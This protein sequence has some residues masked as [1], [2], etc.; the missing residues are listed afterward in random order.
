MAL[1]QANVYSNVLG[2]EVAIELIIPQTTTKVIGTNTQGAKEDIPVLYLLHGMGGN[3][4]V[5]QRRTAIERYV[6]NYNLAVVMPSTD[7]GF[8]TDTTYDMNY[9]TY[10]SEE[11]PQ[12]IHELFPQLSTKREKTFAA[13]LSMGGY[14]AVKLGLR[15]P[16]RFAAVASLSGAVALGGAVEQLFQVRRK[17]YWEGIFGP[18]EKLASSDNNPIH[19]VHE[20]AKAGTKTPAIFLACGEE[21][22]LF[23]ASQWLAQELG[24]AKLPVTFEHGPGEHNWEFWDHWIQRVLEWLPLNA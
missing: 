18:L 17:E 4:T 12:L 24:K 19:L 15:Q 5:W 6:G 16:E 7:L 14:G 21:D 20:L 11:L 10:L 1:I 2:M 8:Y 23:A 9:W 13:G 3:Q 22:D